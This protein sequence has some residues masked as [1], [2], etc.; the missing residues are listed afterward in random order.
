[1]SDACDFHLIAITGYSREYTY[2]LAY[3]TAAHIIILS[4][5]K[6]MSVFV[7]VFVCVY[8][9]IWMCVYVCAY[10]RKRKIEG[11]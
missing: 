2:M 10:E 4:R 7:F 6:Y 3:V 1:M 8:V 11:E 5:L 9:C